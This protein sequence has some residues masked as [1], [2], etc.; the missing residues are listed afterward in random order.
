VVV[1]IIDTLINQE[2]KFVCDLQQQGVSCFNVYMRNFTLRWS[3]K[4]SVMVLMYNFP[5]KSCK[6]TV[7][8]ILL[9]SCGL[10]T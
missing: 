8:F 6:I 5:Q 1:I 2:C 9:H 4:I 10:R 3:G 7:V